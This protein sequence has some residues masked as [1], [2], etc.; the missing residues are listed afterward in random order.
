MDSLEQATVV[1]GK[2]VTF[3]GGAGC[4]RRQESRHTFLVAVRFLSLS[5]KD[6]LGLLFLSAGIMA[7]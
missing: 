3:P 7:S 1:V 4:G 6:Q 5:V 2:G